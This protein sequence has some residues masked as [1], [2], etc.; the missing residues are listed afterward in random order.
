MQ[1]EAADQ[2]DRQLQETR[3]NLS[4]LQSKSTHSCLTKLIKS[5]Y[6]TSIRFC[7]ST[8]S[9]PPQKNGKFK[10]FFYSSDKQTIGRN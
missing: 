9:E 7:A 6:V 4:S 2:K 10:A 3:V 5:L 8:T 1:L